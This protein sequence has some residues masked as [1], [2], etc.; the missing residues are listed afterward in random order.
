[1]V[2]A[3]VSLHIIQACK[4]VEGQRRTKGLN[5]KQITSLLKF[6]CQRPKEQE[7]EILQVQLLGFCLMGSLL[8]LKWES[9]S[10]LNF[11]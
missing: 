4:I 3:F 11:F 10:G 8:C 9:I 5:N 7:K 1:M 2:N 6:S